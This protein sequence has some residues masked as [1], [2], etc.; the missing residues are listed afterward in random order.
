MRRR[1]D[2]GASLVGRPQILF[3]DEPTTGLDPRGRLGLW[4]V[5]H[6]IVGDG[7]TLLLTTQYMEEADV[8][9]DKIAVIDVGKVIAEGTAD[10]LKNRVG[11]AVLQ[12]RVAEPGSF[13]A[14]V[15]AIG[16]LRPG[17]Q[18]D[19]ETSEITIPVGND[20]AQ[21]MV[22]AVRLLDE[23]KVTLADIAL[24]RPTLDDVFLAL[25]GHA[26]DGGVPRDEEGLEAGAPEKRRRTRRRR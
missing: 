19:K 22:D 17:L 8:L 21:V 3:L 4:D 15:G 18:L 9:A 25:T 2:L 24:R 5:I 23:E 26:A 20:G 14:A 1:L 10:E 12:L 6:E 16:G 7:T 11:G 13:S